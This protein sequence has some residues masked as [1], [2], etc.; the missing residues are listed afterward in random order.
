MRRCADSYSEGYALSYR[1]GWAVPQIDSAAEAVG[2]EHMNDGI[3]GIHHITAIASDPQRNVDFYA[4]VLGLRLVK[5]TVNFDDPSSYHF[6]YGDELG[7]PGTILTFFPWP[8]APRGSHGNGQLTVTSFSIAPDSMGFWL[9]RLRARDV[10]LEGPCTHFHEESLEFTD[11]DGLKLEL[12]ANQDAEL[13]PGWERGPVPAVHTIRGFHGVTLSEEGY[14]GTAELLHGQMGFEQ[15]ESFGNRFRYAVGEG[16]DRAYVDILCLPAG[17]VGSMAVGT[18]H[19]IAWRVANDESQLQ[20]R[21][22]LV[23][24]N[25]Y[26]TPVMDR[27]YFHSIYYREPGGIIFEIAT[28]PPG[29]ATDETPES[30]GS[31]LML[32]PWLE[33]RRKGIEEVLLPISLAES[34]C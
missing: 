13:R 8:G 18:V 10:A 12:V 14:D 2:V 28:D 9:D 23:D 11:H 22:R 27:Q 6:Y 34:G 16:A 7:R 20:W 30:L 25:Y 15:G 17:R 32:P 21:S 19:H 29:F 24:L 5:R 3:L 26:V 33:A 31:H 4:G 1:E